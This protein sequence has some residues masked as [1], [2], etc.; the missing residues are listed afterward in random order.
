METRLRSMR[1]LCNTAVAG[2]EC[3]HSP[4]EH[5]QVSACSGHCSLL[6]FNVF[7]IFITTD[8]AVWSLGINSSLFIRE[9]TIPISRTAESGIT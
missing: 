6:F 3:D 4:D 7:V 5:K 8:E 2:H 1:S 9:K